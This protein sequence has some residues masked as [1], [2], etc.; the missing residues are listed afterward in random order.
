MWGDAKE[1]LEGHQGWAVPREGRPTA[2]TGCD[3][4]FALGSRR[5]RATWSQPL[6]RHQGLH[7]PETMKQTCQFPTTASDRFLP[8]ACGAEEYIGILGLSGSEVPDASL[9]V[10]SC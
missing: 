9:Q 1:G 10:T 7:H 6:S 5:C 3:P 4:R 2:P 8:V